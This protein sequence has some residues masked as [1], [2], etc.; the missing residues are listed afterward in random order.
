[1]G[2][3]ARDIQL[4]EGRVAH[5]M[6]VATIVAQPVVALELGVV[7]VHAPG[8]GLQGGDGLWGCEGFRI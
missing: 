4:P 1:M 7:G 2:Q 3:Q 8:A 6:D 5:G